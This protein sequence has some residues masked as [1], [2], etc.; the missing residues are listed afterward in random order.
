MLRDIDASAEQQDKINGIVNGAVDDL[1]RLRE[2]HQQNRDAFHAQFGGTGA[3]DRAALEE[4]RK[5][6]MGLADEASKRLL[7]ALADVSGHPD[8]RA[9][10][11][12]GRAD[13]PS[14][15]PSERARPATGALPSASMADRILMIEDDAHLAAMVS[16]YL[17]PT[18]SRSRS[19]ARGARPLPP[20]Q[21]L[22]PQPCSST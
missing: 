18:A 1:F 7:Q 2:K 3:V 4:I 5:S 12:P 15:T 9:A 21:R 19:P 16:E 22:L 6:E 17:P 11:G 20:R 14:T 13:P 8:P 10:P